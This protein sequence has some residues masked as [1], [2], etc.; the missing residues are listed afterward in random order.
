MFNYR[1]ARNKNI[2]DTFIYLLFITQTVSTKGC[3][4]YILPFFF[5]I[6]F[7]LEYLFFLGDETQWCFDNNGALV[8]LCVFEK[9]M[10]K[11]RG[12]QPVHLTLFV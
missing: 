3:N 2:Y 9:L 1:L 8:F 5:C 4:T 11:T 10:Q 12:K 6:F 7:F